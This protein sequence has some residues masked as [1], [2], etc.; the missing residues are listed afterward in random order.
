MGQ[1][2]DLTLPF[3]MVSCQGVKGDIYGIDFKLLPACDSC[4]R[5]VIFCFG[6]KSIYS[7]AKGGE[8]LGAF[9][10]RIRID[11]DHASSA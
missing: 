9:Y 1:L 10:D 2:W 5:D 3:G 6:N 7:N 11:G 4:Q 8:G